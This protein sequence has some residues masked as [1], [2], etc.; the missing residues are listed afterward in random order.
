M[1]RSKFTKKFNTSLLRAL[2]LESLEARHLLSAVT[3]TSGDSTFDLSDENVT[4]ADAA[5]MVNSTEGDYADIDSIEFAEDVNSIFLFNQSLSIS[6]VKFD[7]VG[8]IMS[9]DSSVS[10][11]NCV[12]TGDY[13]TN[14]ITNQGG[15]LVLEGCTF[16]DINIRQDS[17][18]YDLEGITAVVYN[19]GNLEVLTSVFANNT[20]SPATSRGD[21]SVIFSAIYNQNDG[22]DPASIQSTLIYGTA[23]DSSGIKTPA[24]WSDAEVNV[25]AYGIATAY[26]DVELLNDTVIDTLGSFRGDYYIQN[27][28]YNS[29]V[30]LERGFIVLA[31]GATNITFTEASELEDIYA[32]FEAAT[33]SFKNNDYRVWA[34]AA[35][36][37]AG[38]NSRLLGNLDVRQMPRVTGETVDIGAVESQ[39]VK[40]GNLDANAFLGDDPLT[41]I[42]F[43][44][45]ND[46]NAAK[47]ILKYV[48][49][50]EEPTAIGEGA[51]VVELD[52]TLSLY[53]IKTGQNT[54]GA[55]QVM[56]V[57]DNI[58]FISSDWSVIASAL[59]A[60]E[61]QLAAPTELVA[62]LETPTSMDLAWPL[63]T[64]A[65]GYVLQYRPLSNT[66]GTVFHDANNVED[67]ENGWTNI[68]SS[69]F[70]LTNYAD[71]ILAG[72]TYNT[73]Y[74]F[75]VKAVGNAAEFLLD[76]DWV[77]TT[78][79]TGLRLEP[80][81]FTTSD[82]TTSSVTI[83]WDDTKNAPKDVSEY[84]AQ[85]QI[86][87]SNDWLTG[88]LTVNGKS[89]AV[90]GLDEGVT[91]NFRVMAKGVKRFS[92]D[93]EWAYTANGVTTKTTLET[94]D[95]SAEGTSISTIKVTWN[96]VENASG[97]TLTCSKDGQNYGTYTITTEGTTCTAVISGLN[98][99]TLYTVTVVAN[100]TGDY[101]DSEPATDDAATFNQL[102]TPNPTITDR[103]TASVTASW[104]AVTGATGYKVQV[105]AGG[106]EV[107]SATTT[108]LT[109]TFTETTDIDPAITVVFNVTAIGNGSDILDSE[110]GSTS[111]TTIERLVLNA[112]DLSAAGT[113]DTTIKVDWNAVEN[114][115][116]YDILYRVNGSNGEYVKQSVAKNVTTL[117]LTGLLADT[118]YEITLQAKGDGE[119]FSDS[120]V[121]STTA[122]TWYKLAVPRLGSNG[123]T[124]SSVS[125][126]WMNYADNA[127]AN[128][129]NI[130]YRVEG[131]TW[132]NTSSTLT[133]KDITNLSPA[134]KYQ[135]RIQAVGSS[136]NETVS[137]DWSDILEVTTKGILPA[138]EIVLSNDGMFAIDV[139][140]DKIT[141]ADGYEIQWRKQGDTDWN[142]SMDVNFEGNYITFLCEGLTPNTTYEF[143]VKALANE[144]NEDYVS[145]EFS[146]IESLTTAA[147][148][149]SPVPTEVE[150][151]TTS[152]SITIQWDAVPD[153]NAYNV[154]CKLGE[155]AIISTSTEQSGLTFKV[156]GLNPNTTYT[157][158]VTALNTNTNRESETPG[159]VDVTTD[160]ALMNKPVV[161]PS[162][163]NEQILVDWNEVTNAVSYKLY[164]GKV[165]EPMTLLYEGTNTTFTQ[166]SWESGVTYQFQVQ[167]VGS[168]TTYDAA[169]EIAT[170][171]A[172]T[173]V[174][175]ESV[176][177]TKL[178]DAA[179]SKI[180]TSL[181]WADE[182]QTVFVEVWTKDTEGLLDGRSFTFTLN[183]DP[184]LYTIEGMNGMNGF[185]LVHNNDGS[186]TITVNDEFEAGSGD[187]F[188]GY[189]KLTPIDA[190]G[191]NWTDVVNQDAVEFNN[192][193]ILDVYAVPGDLNDD[194]KILIA[195][196]G[197]DNTLFDNEYQTKKLSYA[198]FDGNEKVTL[199]DR[200]WMIDNNE[201]KTFWDEE[202]N[203]TYPENFPYSIAPVVQAILA[204]SLPT[205]G[206]LNDIEGAP[207]SAIAYDDVFA[208]AVV[209]IEA[210][211]ADPIPVVKEENALTDNSAE[212]QKLPEAQNLEIVLD[213]QLKK[214]EVTG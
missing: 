42:T 129:Y 139:A 164:G 211:D 122:D 179:D 94:F 169:S 34:D 210:E 60:Q 91:V 49:G 194:G 203:V 25:Q 165:G 63:V 18:R 190:N 196:D 128:G 5:Y 98:P 111:G 10:F 2:R 205:T 162:F 80:V 40:I 105:L 3:V 81:T 78:E 171:T 101:V 113:S 104:G 182:W 214:Q 163:V 48:T 202:Y 148:L 124:E 199:K 61:V 189:F 84:V 97:Y 85:Y 166:T 73:T 146:E 39:A 151:A 130:Q 19:E 134:A 180:P 170:I 72:L 31:D 156:E 57:G 33:M 126:E 24:T 127:L 141:G 36:V 108:N 121:L 28:V 93:S 96:A 47:Y 44:W 145:S 77:Y 198:D 213:E 208:E 38:T 118:T 193:G 43:Q 209:E 116:G 45:H 135:F 56:A 6:G 92:D 186:W 29:N 74:Q 83:N 11:S 175:L 200:K 174:T 212:L 123:K 103:T 172:P 58:D 178:S 88:N 12:F 131:G 70:Q 201:G 176:V 20:Y 26:T 140:W 192:N 181:E 50:S 114:A 27:S 204:A 32:F 22:Y 59:T 15:S 87:G 119:D 110:A 53:K 100:G 35:T 41:D 82:R 144:T 185:D 106:V 154:V 68:D 158:E 64:N 102:S 1:Q 191:V 79:T 147:Y 132:T 54:W 90:T 46:G 142:S 86:E 69:L 125:L 143:R 138:P 9:G 112:G 8:I 71:C 89:A 30:D 4:L 206:S 37:D 67:A 150:D 188:I 183:A 66:S 107:S 95:I 51:T 133:A 14:V 52:G 55:F 76:S 16:S 23:I 152:S 7:G 167:A 109:Y 115:S 184:D 149:A 137:S 75:R 17:G 120:N 160:K 99:A 153:A 195:G 62:S 21:V 173:S 13:T 155:A 136:T 117:T 187:T 161:T 157:F 207:V 159:T 197:A 177:V 168:E 65:T